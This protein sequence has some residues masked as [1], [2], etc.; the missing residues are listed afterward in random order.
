MIAIPKPK[1]INAIKAY[2]KLGKK[3]TLL[4]F[5]DKGFLEQRC[6]VLENISYKKSAGLPNPCMLIIKGNVSEIKW[7]KFIQLWEG[8]QFVL[9][10]G[11]HKVNTDIVV[12][13]STINVGTGKTIGEKRWATY[14]GRYLVRAQEGI[15]VEP[16]AE[17]IAP[18][19]PEV[20]LNHQSISEQ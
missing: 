1:G 15:R 13:R 12:Q 18:L 19:E 8:K 20:L 9:W 16:V 4:T 14:D 7:N 6:F 3:Y 11:Y 2:A 10:E 17:Y 5:N